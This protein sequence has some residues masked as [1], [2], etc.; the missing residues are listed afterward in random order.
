MYDS[1]FIPDMFVPFV[2]FMFLCMTLLT[3]VSLI[4]EL[5]LWV[6]YTISFS[7]SLLASYL[8]VEARS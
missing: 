1:D 7:A 3:T 2:S 8:Y 6:A 4:S 5:S